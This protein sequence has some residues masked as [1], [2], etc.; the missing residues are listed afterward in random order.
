MPIKGLNDLEWLSK[1][2]KNAKYRAASLRPVYIQVTPETKLTCWVWR[3]EISLRYSGTR[4]HLIH[5]THSCISV[6]QNVSQSVSTEKSWYV[7]SSPDVASIRHIPLSRDAS[8]TTSMTGALSSSQRPD[9]NSSAFS[10]TLQKNH[11]CDRRLLTFIL[12][13]IQKHYTQ[14]SVAVTRWYGIVVFNV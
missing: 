9:T 4:L 11:L 8:S 6:R 14:F 13:S 3:V 1:I 2:Y 7:S 12:A 5:R 10:D